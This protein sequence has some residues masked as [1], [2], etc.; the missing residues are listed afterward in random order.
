MPSLKTCRVALIVG[1]CLTAATASA[2]EWGNLKGRFIFDGK[3]PE[4]AKIN[5]TKDV[6]V[7]SKHQLYDES[8]VV[9]EDGGIANIV[10]YLR[11][12]NPEVHPDYA[13]KANEPVVLDNKGCRFEPHMVAVRTGQ[14]LEIKNS[15]PVGHNTNATTRANP[16]FNVIIASGGTDTKTLKSAENLPVEVACNIHPWM[17]GWLV[18]RPD[19]YFAVSAEDG[20][21][22]IK[23]LPAGKELEFQVWQ[24]KSGYVQKAKIDG[25]P[26]DWARGR[27]KMT[28]KPGDND[29]GEIKLDAVQ[30]AK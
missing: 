5:P 6:E 7:C 3:R 29:L 9:S 11:T 4:P 21:F 1:A 25:K 17:K 26:A 16:P 19:P 30:F 10:V 23:N 12:K 27:F 14:P 18:V 13:A 15:D 24:E 8:L 22:E 2:A 28:I 20:T